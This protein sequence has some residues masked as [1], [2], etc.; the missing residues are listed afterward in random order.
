M[1]K[2]VIQVPMD[3]ELLVSL[4]IAANKQQKTRAELIR[5]ACLSYLRRIEEDEMDNIYR[6]GYEKVPERED[7]G[8]AQAALTGSILPVERW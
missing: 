6:R 1:V 4:K 2:K 7:I 5:E 3:S 8:R